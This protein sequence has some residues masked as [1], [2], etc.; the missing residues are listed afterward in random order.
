MVFHKR[1]MAQSKLKLS[2]TFSAGAG[3]LQWE[4]A[5]FG[6]NVIFPPAL[7]GFNS[8]H[9]NFSFPKVGISFFTA[10][11]RSEIFPSK[12]HCNLNSLRI[13]MMMFRNYKKIGGT[14]VA[15]SQNHTIIIEGNLMHV[16][17]LRTPF[18]DTQVSL[19]QKALILGALFR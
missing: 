10:F 16:N 11:V 5:Q 13:M 4:F 17:V 19:A 18:L 14:H 2:F 7:L 8:F 6:R 12:N 3:A 1:F 9:E 15:L